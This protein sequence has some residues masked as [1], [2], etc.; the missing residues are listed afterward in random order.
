MHNTHNACQSCG[1]PFRNDP[2]GGG[3]N[4]DGSKSTT[5]CSHCYQNG[6]FTQ[7]N[8]TALE[9]QQQV[10]EKLKSLGLF[11]RIFAGLFVKGIPNLERWK[12]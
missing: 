5:Y 7:P 1:M 9:M 8:I 11:H 4:A 3:T 6:K 10:K 12:R 2:Q